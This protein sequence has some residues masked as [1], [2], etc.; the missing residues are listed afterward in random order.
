[1][2]KL[3]SNLCMFS[4]FFVFFYGKVSQALFLNVLTE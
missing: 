3:T 2:H 4:L 1:M